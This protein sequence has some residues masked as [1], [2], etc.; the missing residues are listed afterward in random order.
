M[1]LFD[2]CVQALGENVSVLSDTESSE[3]SRRFQE[4]FPFQSWGRI[5]WDSWGAS[6]QVDQ[7]APRQIIESISTPE[8]LA[9]EVYIIWDDGEL[10]V[11]KAPLKAVLLALDDV[12]A[13]S[14]DT[15]IF[16][17][18]GTYIIEFHHEGDIRLGRSKAPP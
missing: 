1:N 15:W 2:E 11:L 18:D 9:Y 14:F 13:V 8:E 4:I 3:T 17:A 10:P 7:Q 6:I 12:T 5:D 16:R